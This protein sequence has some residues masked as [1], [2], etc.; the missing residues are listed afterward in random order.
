ME[1]DHHIKLWWKTDGQSEYDVGWWAIE[2]DGAGNP[3][4]SEGRVGEYG[5]STPEDA[6]AVQGLYQEFYGP[7]IWEQPVPG[8]LTF[9]GRTAA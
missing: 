8:E 9:I 1:R 4:G 7:M 3:V 2:F 6:A 5:E